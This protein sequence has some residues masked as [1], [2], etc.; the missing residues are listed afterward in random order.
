MAIEKECVRN[1][2]RCNKCLQRVLILNMHFND[3]LCHVCYLKV[4]A[5]KAK[6]MPH[7]KLAQ[8]CYH[9]L[10]KECASQ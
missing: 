7:N 5:K 3:E 10:L 4:W 6:N 9:Q 2:T 8:D 1:N